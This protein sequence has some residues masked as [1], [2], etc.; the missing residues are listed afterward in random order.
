MTEKFLEEIYELR[1][2]I[3]YN[4]KPKLHTESVAEHSFY[5]TLISLELCKEYNL[6]DDIIRQCLIKALLH[7][8]P[9]MEINDITHEAKEKLGI[10]KLLE[11]YE[12]E[13]Y[14]KNYPEYVRLMENNNN[15]VDAI[16]EYADILSVQQYVNLEID[17]GN[18][19]KDIKEI[20]NN[21][22]KRI[23]DIK[24]KLQQL[25]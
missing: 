12:N 16:V 5:V 24:Q 21:V 2:L 15:I 6:S 14:Q 3:R 8:M 25:L 19:T 18:Q 1:N 4:N 17:L 20:S 23:T 11:K 9:E 7:D 13:F 22:Q 10:R